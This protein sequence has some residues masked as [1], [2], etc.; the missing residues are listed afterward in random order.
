[1]KLPEFVTMFALICYKTKLPQHLWFR[2]RGFYW[3]SHATHWSR[4]HMLLKT[5]LSPPSLGQWSPILAGFYLRSWL[6]HTHHFTWL[7]CH[8]IMLYSQNGASPVS[9][10]Q[11]SSNLVGLWVWMKGPHLLFQ[12]TCPTSDHVLFERRHVSTNSKPQNSAGD[13]KQRKTHNLKAF[14]IRFILIYS[15]LRI[16]KLCR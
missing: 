16:S 9:K 4:D 2:V 1:M 15:T 8:V 11:W 3:P 7:I 6:V 12:V 5:G 14:N 10:R 13:I